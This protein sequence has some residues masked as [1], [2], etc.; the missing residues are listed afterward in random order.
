MTDTEHRTTTLTTVGSAVAHA[1]LDA[2]K[3]T[4][5]GTEKLSKQA[6]GFRRLLP[7]T[8]NSLMVILRL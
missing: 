3:G 8:R 2:I 5:E 7:H 6:D 1:L 4:Q